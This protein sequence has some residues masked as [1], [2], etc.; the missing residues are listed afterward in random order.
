MGFLQRQSQPLGASWRSDYALA[1]AVGAYALTGSS[2]PAAKASHTGARAGSYAGA[3]VATTL[4][5][6][7]G[8]NGAAGT[9]TL[10]GPASTVRAD[11]KVSITAGSYTLSG[12]A[13]T[14]STVV[15]RSILASA[16][17]YTFTGY[18]SAGVTT[19]S[20]ASTGTSWQFA[21][22]VSNDL[23]LFISR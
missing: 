12:F 2:A 16:G 6:T 3:G 11:R 17:T 20:N 7:R 1:L 10:S 21:I 15:A 19:G 18:D 14:S 4:P 23:F 13:I 22:R 8:I 5:F 9:Y